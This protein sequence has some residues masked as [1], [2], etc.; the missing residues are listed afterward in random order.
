[1]EKARLEVQEGL[2][3]QAEFFPKMRERFDRAGD[4]PPATRI[5]RM[6]ADIDRQQVV[7]KDLGHEL[8]WGRLTAPRVKYMAEKADALTEYDFFYRG[9]SSSVHASLHHLFRMVWGDPRKGVFSVNNDHLGAYYARF[10]LVWGTWL[11]EAVLDVAARELPELRTARPI[12][13][14]GI[15][16]ATLLVPALEHDA[17]GIVTKEEL[18]WDGPLLEGA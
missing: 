11:M 10:A 8:G 14:N 4:A 13:A 9:A 5:A 18:R 15:W 7:L 6:K 16:L 2:L 17:P 12:D 3:A 1:V